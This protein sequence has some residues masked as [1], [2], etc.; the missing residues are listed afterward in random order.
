MAAALFALNHGVARIKLNR[1]LVGRDRQT[2]RLI[3]FGFSE[4]CD[5]QTYSRIGVT[6]AR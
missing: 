6:A 1:A 4:F 2:D 3:F 5:V